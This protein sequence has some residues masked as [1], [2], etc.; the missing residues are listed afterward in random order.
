[1]SIPN[2]ILSG[3]IFHPF[4]RT[5][6]MLAELLTEHGIDS[7]VTEDI[8]AGIA[9]LS[10]ASAPALL[11]V[12]ALRWRMAGEKYDEYRDAGFFSLSAAGRKQLSEHVN[13]GGGLLVL[14]TG[15][16]CFDDWS[17]WSELLGGCWEWGRSFHPAAGPVEVA[18]TSEPHPITA[19]I[20]GFRLEED[21]VYS[22][23]NLGE[24]LRPLLRASNGEN[25]QPLC[26]ARACGK[27]RVVYNALGHGEATFRSATF[28]RLVARS[29]LWALGSDDSQVEAI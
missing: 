8:E 19:G 13:G 27:G 21:E 1:M 4:A 14:H 28:R 2:T 12:N 10:H 22:D 11:S 6:E 16:I 29:A 18:V 7:R 25:E 26:W 23:L 5:S 9:G 3:G 17:G 20:K 24:G 15:S